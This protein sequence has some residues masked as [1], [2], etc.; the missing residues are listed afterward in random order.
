MSQFE[1]L[2]S[3]E[4]R[5]NGAFLERLASFGNPENI[6]FPI[7]LQQE[8][9]ANMSFVGLETFIKRAIYGEKMNKPEY[10]RQVVELSIDNFVD[11][12]ASAQFAAFA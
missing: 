9:T 7:P 8:K 4:Q 5:P 10:E 3:G 1:E 6:A 2:V 11:L 12:A